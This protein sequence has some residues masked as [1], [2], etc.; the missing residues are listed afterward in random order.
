METTLERLASSRVIHYAE[1]VGVKP[2]GEGCARWKRL[3]AHR[4]ALLPDF[5][6]DV[7]GFGR[8]ASASE[9]VLGSSRPV[10]S[11]TRPTRADASAG[12][13]QGLCRQ[14]RLT[15]HSG[16]RVPTGAA[17]RSSTRW[18][19]HVVGRTHQGWQPSHN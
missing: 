9:L 13:S 10:N 1:Q 4:P 7:C 19:D 14:R 6:D 2:E 12:R 18:D 5:H 16:L 17:A 11:A 15:T 3:S 8:R